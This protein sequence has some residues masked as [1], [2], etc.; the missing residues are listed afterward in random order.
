ML[1]FALKNVLKYLF[2]S[3][4]WTSTKIWQKRSPKKITFHILQSTS[5]YKKTFVATPSWPK[6]GVFQLVFFE[7]QN[8]EV[9]QKA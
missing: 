5:S 2:Y 3:V 8:I 9:E 4:F 7:I 1:F 6:I